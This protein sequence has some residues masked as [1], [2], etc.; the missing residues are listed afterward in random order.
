MNKEYM[1]P[2]LAKGDCSMKMR[3]PQRMLFIIATLVLYGYSQTAQR[4]SSVSSIIGTVQIRRGEGSNW[5]EV[6]PGMPLREKDA[7]R[8]FVESQ[9][10]L[11]LSDGSIL[12]MGENTTLEMSLL[13][14]DEDVQNTSVRIL[15]GNVMAN[16]RK[17]INANSSFDF[18]TPTATAGIRGTKVGFNVGSNTTV[19]RVYEGVV[20][21]KPTGATQGVEL[22]DGQMALIED[23]Q[24][25]VVVEDIDEI[26]DDEITDDQAKAGVDVEI[27][28]AISAPAEGQTVSS[29]LVSITG[30]TNPGADVLVSGIR[31]VVASDGSFRGHVPLPDEEGEHLLEFEFNYQSRTVRAVRTVRYTPEFNFVIQSPAE[32]QEFTTTRI[33]Y[34]GELQPASAELSIDG[35]RVQVAANGL[36]SGV[37]MIPE[38]E[39]EVHLEFTIISG[40]RSRTETRTVVYRRPPDTQAPIIQ[41]TLPEVSRQRR[42]VFTVIDRTPD[43]EITFF[44]EMNGVR[45]RESG[46]PNSPFY[47]NLLDGIH[48]YVVYA[49]D[50]AGNRS[51]RLARTVAYLESAVWQIRMRRPAGDAVV[52]IPPYAPSASGFTPRYTIELSIENLPD[53]NPALIREITVSNSAIGSPVSRRNLSHVDFLEFDVELDRDKP[54][55]ITVQV[56]DVNDVIK[57]RQFK[58]NVR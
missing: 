49:E 45:E 41:G 35:R 54:N 48:D 8:T 5:R 14:H 40:E 52:H 24:T 27:H 17:L 31:M 3:F 6:R 32:G 22:T 42:L 23:Q 50:R 7:L 30:T 38:E 47:L 56:R 21:V 33:Q 19:I 13:S 2:S 58:I 34:R 25:G 20:Y 15:N 12:R 26:T 43:D 37:H 57:T 29:T 46:P 53:Q 4:T 51:Q 11:E 44:T 10:E 16:I 28:R 36:F 9:V 1:T 18:E 55:Q 39:G